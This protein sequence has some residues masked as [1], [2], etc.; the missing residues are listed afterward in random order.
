MAVAPE[1]GWIVFVI[2]MTTE[3]V[4]QAM[5]SESHLNSMYLASFVRNSLVTMTPVTAEKG[6]SEENSP[7]LRER[8]LYYSIKQYSRCS[9]KSGIIIKNAFKIVYNY[10]D[11]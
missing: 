10:R 3:A 9:L 6:M 11:S 8:G 2:V 1:G 5:A 4:A 7:R